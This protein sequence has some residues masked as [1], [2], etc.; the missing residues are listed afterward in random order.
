MNDLLGVALR[1]EEVETHAMISSHVDCL[2]IVAGPVRR[3]TVL[4][5]A[6]VVAA[7]HAVT[8]YFE[9]IETISKRWLLSGLHWWRW[10]QPR[11]R[12]RQWHVALIAEELDL[13]ASVRRPTHHAG[14]RKKRIVHGVG[15]DVCVAVTEGDVD[16]DEIM[17]VLHVFPDRWLCEPIGECVVNH[18]VTRC[19]VHDLVVDVTVQT[20]LA[21]GPLDLDLQKVSA[22]IWC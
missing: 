16:N 13:A 9:Q 12:Y 17:D 14:T 22:H 2:I 5:F 15:R 8:H 4:A 18:E 6:A 7:L 1:I 19:T 20:V 10:S 21:I 3:H 11:C